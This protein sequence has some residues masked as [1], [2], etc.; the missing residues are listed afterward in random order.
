MSFDL[1]KSWQ[2][3]DR[4]LFGK[5][6]AG[7][8]ILI[9][10]S[11]ALTFKIDS[12]ASDKRTSDQ[13]KA[14][15]ERHVLTLIARI[16]DIEGDLR[17]IAN[18][19]HLQR[20]FNQGDRR[21][22][23]DLAS[24]FS[25]FVKAK[26]VYDQARYIDENGMER[27]RV[28][29]LAGDAKIVAEDKLQNK[30][31]RYF[32]TDT[33]QLGPGEVFISPF[34]LNIEGN[35]IEVPY[36]PMIRLA[37][38]LFDN[39]GQR[40]GIAI[41]NYL[42]NDLIQRLNSDVEDG[43]SFIELLNRD[44]YWL[45]SQKPEQEWGFMFNSQHTFAADHPA[46]WRELQEKHAGQM[47]VDGTLWTWVRIYPLRGDMRSSSGTPEVAGVS[48]AALA[49][50]EYYWTA[51]SQ[52]NKGIWALERR[53]SLMLY[54]G[55]WLAAMM[56]IAAVSWMIALREGRLNLARLV[57]EN[58]TKR[59]ELLLTSVG[60]GI[61]GVD[62]TGK[63]IFVNPAAR[64]LFGWSEEEGIGVDLHAYT[65]HHHI[66][67][68]PYAAVDCPI[69]VTLQDG[70][71]QETIKDW[72]WR[73]DGSPF[74][75]EFTAMPITEGGKIIGAVTVFRDISDR[76]EADRLLRE[77]KERLEA[78][79]SAGIVGVWDW[80]IPNNRFVWDKVMNHLYG[81]DENTRADDAYQV[82]SNALHPEDKDYVIGEVQAALRGEISYA[83]EFR[84]IAPD[85]RIRHIK[86]QGRVTF[87]EHG[88]P[89]RMI[90]VNYDIS[91]QK[92]IEAML[93]EG[94]AKR[95]Q[96]LQKALQAAEVAN[97]AKTAFLANMSHEMRTPLHQ[98]AGLTQLV[99]R[100]PLT[101][102]QVEYLSKLDISCRNL[103][104]IIDTILE[105]TRIEA[106]QFDI[107]PVQFSLG[108]LLNT[109]ISTIQAKAEEKHLCVSVEVDG[110][111]E[112][113]VGDRKLVL[114]AL[115]NYLVNAIRFTEVG[116]VTVRVE[117]LTAVGENMLVRFAVEDTG[118]GIA[119]DDLPRL[120]SIFEQADMS[121]TRKFGGIGLGLA[122]SKKIAEV[123]GGYAGCDSKPGEGSTFWFTVRLTGAAATTR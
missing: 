96:E 34:D 64:R 55:L 122:M 95:T 6:L 111:P 59:S 105:L 83:P 53:T 74:P 18:N 121:T 45:K 39:Q 98:I 57:A 92:N 16:A 14:H 23:A 75:V 44:G 46:V 110:V 33:M 29:L 49:A 22:I 42:G 17:L 48:R 24:D 114:Q 90:G 60:D 2:I 118:M 108:E 91:E 80:D 81:I 113:L 73:K 51:V 37:T 52:K 77:T 4:S 93:K 56:L 79:A 112:R 1:K 58:A 123:L 70:A 104:T 115:Q 97:I 3:L 25:S 41:L 116:S 27:V 69:Y 13:E 71:P 62:T 11:I 12:D 106:G 78:A 84:I 8:A 19:S 63:T 26:Q 103:T 5:V 21:E 10:A 120:F 61:C 94:I 101:P 9:T 99:Q 72:F 36:K 40:R 31:T 35:Q 66:D 85:G 100:D 102:K 54:S 43:T 119:P 15:V 82:W 47:Q 38:P 76:E 109:A 68:T 30:G 89:L 88:K 67:G 87:D 50:S 20:W 32:F 117:L 107:V 7:L 65:H 86:A 28:N